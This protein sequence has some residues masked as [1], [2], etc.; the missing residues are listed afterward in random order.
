MERSRFESKPFRLFFTRW[1]L[2]T[3]MASQVGDSV[4]VSCL[5]LSE[6]RIVKSIRSFHSEKS[7]A[8]VGDRIGMAISKF[9][10]SLMERGMVFSNDAAVRHV[11]RIVAR[12]DKIR[13]KQS[14]ALLSLSMQCVIQLVNIM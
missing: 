14:F 5:P 9:D 10:A 6:Q 7:R 8:S 12:V 13:Y 3:L 1:W 11:S 2:L 4:S